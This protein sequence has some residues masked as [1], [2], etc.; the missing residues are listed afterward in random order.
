MVIG[1]LIANSTYIHLLINVNQNMP[2]IKVP[3]SN[4]N[5][6]EIERE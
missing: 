2:H 4:S 6:I 5:I 1:I 3:K